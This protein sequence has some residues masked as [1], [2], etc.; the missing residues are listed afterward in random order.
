[1][2]SVIFYLYIM[3][4]LNIYCDNADI[5]IL[6]FNEKRTNIVRVFGAVHE[7]CAAFV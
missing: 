7:W 2:P 4:L 1:M 5:E 3:S 6:K